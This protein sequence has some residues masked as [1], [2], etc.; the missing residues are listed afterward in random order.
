MKRYT[1]SGIFVR[2]SD[3][4]AKE[5]E[6]QVMKLIIELNKYLLSEYTVIGFDKLKVEPLPF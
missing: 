3:K 1:V 2:V 4:N 6:R 5:A